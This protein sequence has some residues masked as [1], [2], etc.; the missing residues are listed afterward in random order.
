MPLEQLVTFKKLLKP[1]LPSIKPFLPFVRG[2]PGPVTRYQK[3][4]SDVQFLWTLVAWIVLRYIHRLPK[5]EFLDIMVRK[6]VLKGNDRV[7]KSLWE[8]FTS[9]TMYNLELRLETAEENIEYLFGE[10]PCMRPVSIPKK[11][12]PAVLNQ[13]LSRIEHAISV[14]KLQA[15]TGA[16][17]LTNIRAAKTIPLW[18]L[19]GVYHNI[20]DL[21]RGLEPQGRFLDN[22]E[23]T[24]Y[25]LA[26]YYKKIAMRAPEIPKEI[27]SMNAMQADPHIY[28]GMHGVMAAGAIE[29]GG[30]I[31][32][33]G[34]LAFSHNKSVAQA[35]AYEGR[36]AGATKNNGMNQ[37]NSNNNNN[38]NWKSHT[39]YSNTNNNNN[40]VNS[41]AKKSSSFII[42]RDGH[43]FA[44]KFIMFRLALRDV[45]RGTPWIW[46]SNPSQLNFRPRKYAIPSASEESEVLL[47]PGKVVFKNNFDKRV[48]T[49]ISNFFHK[50]IPTNKKKS[51]INAVPTG[52]KTLTIDISSRSDADIENIVHAVCFH[53]QEFLK[54]S[55]PGGNTPTVRIAYPNPKWIRMLVMIQMGFVHRKVGLFDVRDDTS[56][57]PTVFDVI[58]VQDASATDYMTRKISM[59][60][61][62]AS[63]RAPRATGMKR[64][65]TP[66]KNNNNVE[67]YEPLY[68]MFPNVNT[69]SERQKAIQIQSAMSQMKNAVN[70][71]N[72]TVPRRVT[73]SRSMYRR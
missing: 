8:S 1:F 12:S 56:S 31:D 24:N 47:P 28:R 59:I 11:E 62:T 35:F 23:K 20:Q 42:H 54:R 71:L 10:G 32:A 38:G 68:K 41:K 63:V 19:S 13:T 9:D 33:K 45:P 27:V 18:T 61:K 69:P 53:I 26:T 66:S 37:S 57:D 67:G 21:R 46:F 2:G 43:P 6:E 5:Y 60:P 48:S 30:L 50:T 17:A 39:G 52:T 29:H 64:G 70:D 22:A 40:G 3:G 44:L 16:P 15:R 55:P 25:A 7:A 51:V 73:R 49:S 65:R 36:V 72:M 14:A 4:C 34:Y 58:Y